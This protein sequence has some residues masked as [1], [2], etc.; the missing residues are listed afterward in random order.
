MLISWNAVY[1][2]AKYLYEVFVCYVSKGSI[3][4]VV[5]CEKLNLISNGIGV[6]NQEN[7]KT[8]KCIHSG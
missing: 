7:M 2:T 8:F 3:Y 6:T 1:I 5:W 4:F